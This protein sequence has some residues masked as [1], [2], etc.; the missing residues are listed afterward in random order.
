MLYRLHHFAFL[1]A[2]SRVE[3][4]RFVKLRIQPYGRLELPTGFIVL[5]AQR[6]GEPTRGVCLRQFGIELERLPAGRIGALQV[7]LAAV[8]VH[9]KEGTAVRDPGIGQGIARIDLDGPLEHP[10]SKLNSF[11]PE[12]MKVLP[13]TEVVLV[14]L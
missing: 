13:P 14:G 9:I 2:G 4:V 5:S 3:I 8:P 7:G 1:N 6:E 11:A 10:T 12:L